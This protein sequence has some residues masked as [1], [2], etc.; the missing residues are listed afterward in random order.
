MPDTATI[1]KAFHI[2]SAAV[3]VA[4]AAIGPGNGA[5]KK[6]HALAAL[7]EQI[8][9]VAADLGLPSWLVQLLLNEQTLGLLIDFA[10]FAENKAADAV[11]Q[12]LKAADAPLP[13]NTQQ[14]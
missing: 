8:P 13:A 12:A 10:V 2:I 11:T 1:V 5:E 3:Q 4:E 7:K 9:T 14:P 6:A